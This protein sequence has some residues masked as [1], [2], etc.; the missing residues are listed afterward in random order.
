MRDRS[1]NRVVAL[2]A[3]ALLSCASWAFAS[4]QAQG[5]TPKA[6]A[7]SWDAEHVSSPFP[8]LVVHEDVVRRLA[9][10]RKAAP[11]LFSMEEIGK[12]VEGRSINHL[13]FGRGKFQV[14]MW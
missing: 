2:A 7:A 6:L 14:L 10:A 12:S 9:E 3:A 5:M 1:Q 4:P 13:W 11:D 8:Q